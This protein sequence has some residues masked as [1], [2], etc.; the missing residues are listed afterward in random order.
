MHVYR[1]DNIFMQRPMFSSF[2][3]P[4]KKMKCVKKICP[5]QYCIQ[6]LH[7]PAFVAFFKKRLYMYEKTLNTSK[8]AQGLAVCNA[9]LQ[10]PKLLQRI[11]KMAG[12]DWKR[13]DHEDFGRS[14]QLLQNKYFDSS[15]H[16]VRFGKQYKFL[17]SSNLEL[18]LHSTKLGQLTN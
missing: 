18:K 15:S 6:R 12:S 10:L 8:A 9:R 2:A 1:K 13:F 11:F 17:L 16:S 4:Q 3:P 7:C 14:E 5:C